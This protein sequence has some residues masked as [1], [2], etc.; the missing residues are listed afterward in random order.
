MGNK[1]V[2]SNVRFETNNNPEKLDDLITNY[3]NSEK[4][5]NP[6]INKLI[7]DYFSKNSKFSSRKIIENSNLNKVFNSKN[8]IEFSFSIANQIQIKALEK[9]LNLNFHKSLLINS[10]AIQLSSMEDVD[11]NILFDNKKALLQMN[12]F[13]KQFNEDHIDNYF[14]M[15]IKKYN[16]NKKNIKD[17]LQFEKEMDEEIKNLR[18][19]KKI[20]F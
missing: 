6:K 10:H 7:R 8:F 20:Y 9:D 16:N 12:S 4:N 5:K 17:E 2:N 11:N 3:L 15:E 13:D 14:N 1:Q 18:K 19:S